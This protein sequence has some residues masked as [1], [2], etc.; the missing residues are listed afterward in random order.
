MNQDVRLL[1]CANLNSV[2]TANWLA[3]LRASPWQVHAFHADFRDHRAGEKLV[4]DGLYA[5]AVH[6]PSDF[7]AA[8]TVSESVE[9]TAAESRGTVRPYALHRY[10]YLDNVSYLTDLIQCLRP[11]LIHSL[12]FNVNWW[13]LGRV[14]EEAMQRIDAGFRPPWLYSSWGTD[15]DYFARQSPKIRGEIERQL[16]L[17]THHL[18]ECKRDARLA[19]EMGFAG[20][21]VGR[22]PAFGGIVWETMSRFR[23]PAS[24]S[25]RRTLFLKGRDCEE[26]GGDPIGRA[27]TAMRAF[28]LCADVLSGYRIVVARPTPRV[29][30]AAKELQQRFGLNMDIQHDMSYDAVLST[31]GQS[32]ATLAVTIN[33]GLPRIL[34]EAMALGSLPVHSD[35]EPIAE[36]ITNGENGLLVPPE[37][38]EATANAIRHAVSDD[39]LVEHA[40]T[41]NECLVHSHLTNEVVR[42]KA[43]AIY[44]RIAASW[45][46]A[47]D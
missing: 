45:L 30:M 43:L 32:R 20:E 28:A 29:A 23:A 24:V 34:V 47:K 9:H 7:G 19:R 14:V 15:L 27:M 21:F 16:H 35:L 36:W 4:A 25:K 17:C 33:D 44:D 39:A 31:I 40:A 42:P 37:D 1:V 6:I 13:N 22:L 8:L 46:P 12:A 5:H 41:R 3:Q 2:H 26:P 11:T 18:T 10:H 38:V